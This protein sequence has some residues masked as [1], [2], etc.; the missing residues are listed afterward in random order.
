MS[1][2]DLVRAINKVE[3]RCGLKER[4]VKQNVTNF[5]NGYFD[6]G[7]DFTRKV[8][9]A[10][11]LEELTLMNTLRKPKT[12]WEK[13]CYNEALEKYKVVKK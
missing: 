7:Y 4:T 3:E 13:K 12:K 1:N 11:E 2:M 6:W 9:V 5:L 10:L 8:E